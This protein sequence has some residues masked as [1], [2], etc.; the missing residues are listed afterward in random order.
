MWATANIKNLKP[1]SSGY[2]SGRAKMET[3]ALCQSSGPCFSAPPSPLPRSIILCVLPHLQGKMVAWLPT[4]M[5]DGGGGVCARE[6]TS[7]CV[8][9]CILYFPPQRGL[10]QA[11][12]ITCHC[13][14]TTLSPVEPTGGRL[15]APVPF[16]YIRGF[17]TWFT[18][19]WMERGS[20]KTTILASYIL[21]VCV[22]YICV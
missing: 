19:E 17:R 13:L 18:I 12:S 6:C 2:S 8:S 1:S 10:G 14:S 7:V 5:T 15:G 9:M 20:S 11:R 21:C 3:I 4:A 22:L 16:T